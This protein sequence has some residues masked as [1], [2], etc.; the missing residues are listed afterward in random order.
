MRILQQ[1]S[2]FGQE[3]TLIDEV[4]GL[5]VGIIKPVAFGWILK[6]YGAGTTEHETKEIALGR[7]E[8]LIKADIGSTTIKSRLNVNQTQLAL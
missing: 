5:E 8:E 7:A 1:T 6:F 2:M 3:L 4:T